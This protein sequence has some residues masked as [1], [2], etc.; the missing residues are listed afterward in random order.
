MSDNRTITVKAWNGDKI[1]TFDEY[2]KIWIEN[3]QLSRLWI[4]SASMDKIMHIQDCIR[5][6][7]INLKYKRYLNYF[8]DPLVATEG[9][10][11][12]PT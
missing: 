6:L 8:V 1:K 9:L 10:S 12:V 5:E 3:A 2:V 4:D 7:A 11:L